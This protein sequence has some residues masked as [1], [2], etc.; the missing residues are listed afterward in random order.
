LNE[1]DQ[2]DI[3][4]QNDEIWQ[5]DQGYQQLEGERRHG[6]KMVHKKESN[7]NFENEL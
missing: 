5:L 1:V 3:S 2:E 7:K 4:G 6:N